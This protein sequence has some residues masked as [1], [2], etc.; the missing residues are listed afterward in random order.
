[1]RAKK[2]VFQYN[3]YVQACTLAVELQNKSPKRILVKDNCSQK[4]DLTMSTCP[5]I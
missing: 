1:M 3:I 5:A 2:I 4:L